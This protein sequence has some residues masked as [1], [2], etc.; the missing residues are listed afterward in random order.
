METG[1]LMVADIVCVPLQCRIISFSSDSGNAK[2]NEAC[3]KNGFVYVKIHLLQLKKNH[4]D[5]D[6]EIHRRR[7]KRMRGINVYGFQVIH[8]NWNCFLHIFGVDTFVFLQ[9]SSLLWSDHCSVCSVDIPLNAN[10]SCI[11]QTVVIGKMYN[12]I[13]LYPYLEQE[14]NGGLKS[15]LL[16]SSKSFNLEGKRYVFIDFIQNILRKSAWNH[17]VILYY[18]VH[19]G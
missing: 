10:V 6:C 1:E 2:R 14:E 9:H 5:P 17:R 11:L 13:I 3:R 19:Q 16:W 15:K 8:V 18:H 4:I 7:M 12:S